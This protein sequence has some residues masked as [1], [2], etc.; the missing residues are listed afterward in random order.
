MRHPVHA[1]DLLRV[2]PDFFVNCTAQPVQRS[3]FQG[4]A[5]ALGIDDQTAVVGT[6]QPLRPYMAGLAIHFHLGDLRNNG[7][8][9]ECVRDAAAGQDV[10]LAERFGRRARI[11]AV[12]F[13]GGFQN[14]NGPRAPEPAV[15][16][17][18]GL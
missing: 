9:A 8:A 18:G 3:A 12:G 1:R 2:E 14:G 6:Y 16:G 7:L 13:C 4:A 15:I 11:P 17:R 10:S 5:K